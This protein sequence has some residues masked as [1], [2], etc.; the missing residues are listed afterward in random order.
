MALMRLSLYVQPW[1]PAAQ[2]QATGRDVSRSVPPSPSRVQ[3]VRKAAS[4]HSA[5]PGLRATNHPGH[6]CALAHCAWFGLACS[7][8]Q[9]RDPPLGETVPASSHNQHATFKQTYPTMISIRMPLIWQHF[10]QF[11][12]RLSGW[13]GCVFTVPSVL[14]HCS[15]VRHGSLPD[16]SLQR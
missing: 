5:G 6:H 2:K 12:Q 8:K 4:S 1:C 7:S 15:S 13:G 9:A 10:R 11:G 14:A 3:Q 16:D